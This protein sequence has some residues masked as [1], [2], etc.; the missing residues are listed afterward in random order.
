MISYCSWCF[1]NPSRMKK[2][3][4]K[5]TPGSVGWSYILFQEVKE[6]N[7]AIENRL[8]LEIQVEIVYDEA[9][10][11]I[12]SV[13]T[14]CYY[15][16]GA[17]MSEELCY[18]IN[19]LPGVRWVLPDSYLDVKNK[20]YG[21]TL[22]PRQLV[23]LQLANPEIVALELTPDDLF[24]VIASDEVFE[25]LSSQVVVDM[26]FSDCVKEYKPFTLKIDGNLEC[27]A[28]EGSGDESQGGDWQ[29][30]ASTMEIGKH[31]IRVNVI[32]HGLHIDDEF[33]VSVG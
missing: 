29:G 32:A 28:F 33:P 11:K 30:E 12:Y 3:E 31:Q 19:E 16:F 14:R 1:C 21:Y 4:K 27:G 5:N 25:F 2:K 18:K 10:M 24:F 13:S 17:L 7:K 22:L 15:A 6:S 23:V 8:L 20:D 26:A 9:R